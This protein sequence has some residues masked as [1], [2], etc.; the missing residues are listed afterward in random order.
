MH[1]YLS[2]DDKWRMNTSLEEINPLLKKTILFKEDKYFY[3]HPGINPVAIIR[4]LVNNLIYGKKTSGASTITMQV[5]RLLYPAR[6]TY[7]NKISEMFRALQLEYKYSKDDIFRL[8]LNLVPYGGNVEGVKAASLMYFGILP[9]HVNL[10]QS[11]ILSVIPNRPGT[12]HPAKGTSQITT[13]RNKWLNRMKQEGIV[14]ENSANE[15]VQEPIDMSRHSYARNIPHLA[16]RLNTERPFEYQ[17]ITSIDSDIQ[18]KAENICLRHHRKLALKNVKNISVLVIENSSRKVRAYIGSQDFNDTEFSGQ[19][20]G[21]NAIRSPGSTLKPMIYALA[22]DKGIIT[23]ETMLEDVPVNYSGYAPE[24]FNSRCNGLIWA[25]GA[26]AYSL[27]IPAV[28]LLYST[29]L[30]D[31]T[32]R[33]RK[34]G[35]SALRD[36]QEMGLSV[37]LGGCGTRLW[38]LAGM[39]SMFANSGVY[40]PIKYLETDTMKRETRILSDA[41]TFLV[42]EM[43][44]GLVRP[45]LPNNYE[46]SLHVPKIAWK[47]GTSYGRRDAWSIGYNRKYTIAIWAGNFDGTGVP[48]LT[49]A[50]MATP[51]L[52]DLFNSLAD[53][54]EDSWFGAPRSLEVRQVCSHSGLP[55]GEFCTDIII[56]YYIP[57]VSDNRKC[58]HLREIK[59]SADGKFSY[60]MSC[61]PENGYKKILAEQLPAGVAAFYTGNNIDFRKAPPHNPSCNQLLADVPP[62]ITSPVNNKEYLLEKGAAQSLQLTCNTLPDIKTVYWYINDAFLAKCNPG[63]AAFFTPPE[64]E[65]K[66]SCSDDKGMNTDIRITVRMY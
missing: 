4:A 51:L 22:I 10:S 28:S 35:F 41:S 39:Y 23:P 32:S 42:T 60:C 19:V 58:S 62:V 54:T 18:E 61:I 30:P 21:C 52:F 12:L 64:G 14:N 59:V 16:R 66:I 33:L 8:Y 5:A 9:A 1:A 13:V 65:Y 46:S 27:N 50:D 17:T 24:N 26:L 20:D 47:T 55:P 45:D 2:S 6:R 37:I 7:G 48:E 38:E 40:A 25:S 49:G 34:C 36:D 3:Y 15:A 53:A 56:G 11:V 29:G 44:T 43:L 31:F 57:S 63:T